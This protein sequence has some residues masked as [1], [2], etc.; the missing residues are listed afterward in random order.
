MNIS[1]IKKCFPYLVALATFVLFTI[2]YCSPVLEGKSLQGDDVVGWKGQAQEVREFEKNT[3][4]KTFW[5]GSMFSGM[6]SYQISGGKIESEHALGILGRIIKFGFTQTLALLFSFL[7]CTISILICCTH[8]SF[9]DKC[10]RVLLTSFFFMGSG[11]NSC[12]K[13]VCKQ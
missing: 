7:L 8:E 13:N 9:V 3:G 2:I 12:K 10:L 5:T 6:P 1:L 11:I 4:E